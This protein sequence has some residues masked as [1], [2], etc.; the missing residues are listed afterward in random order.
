MK[1]IICVNNTYQTYLT[2]EKEY[3]VKDIKENKVVITDDTGNYGTYYLSRF[4]PSDKN[5]NILKK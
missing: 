5:D 3:L 1:K 4:I 2:L